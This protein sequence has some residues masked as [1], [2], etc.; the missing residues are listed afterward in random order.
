M[1][2]FLVKCRFKKTI[3]TASADDQKLVSPGNQSIS[4]PKKKITISRET[5]KIPILEFPWESG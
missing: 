1:Q 2:V 4:L 3:E 5:I